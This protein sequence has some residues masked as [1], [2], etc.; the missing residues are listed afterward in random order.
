MNSQNKKFKMWSLFP[1]IARDIAVWVP[2]SVPSSDVLKIIKENAGELVVRGPELFDEF[3]KEDKISY[4][5][6]LVFQSYDRTLTDV[7]INEIMDK[8]TS[9][10]KENN[11]WQ[12]R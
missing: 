11:G 8:I 7:E 3:K 12:V 2:E 10:I 4:A 1:F 6:R 5:F 9:K